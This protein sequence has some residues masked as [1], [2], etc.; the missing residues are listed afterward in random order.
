MS[1]VC[2]R[3][4]W[5]Q[6]SWQISST[7]RAP[8][9][10]GNG[11]RSKPARVWPQRAQV[12]V[13]GIGL[14]LADEFSSGNL[15]SWRSGVGV[16]YDR[17]AKR[18]PKRANGSDEHGGA[19]WR[20]RAGQTSEAPTAP[21]GSDRGQ[22]LHRQLVLP[23]GRR[24][25][26]PRVLDLRQAEELE[27]PDVD[28]PDVEL[29][30]ARLELGALR[31]GVMVV[32][33]LLAA[34]PDGDGGDVPAL[35]LHVEVAI[36]ERV[37]DAIDDA[38]RPERDPDHLHA[39]HERS[40]EEAEQPDVDAEHQQDAD[41]VER[42]EQMPL[43]PVGGRALAVF[44]EHARLAH[45]LAVVERALEQDLAQSLDH[46]A[47]R[48]ALAIGERVVLAMAGDPFLGD[49]GRGE[50]EPEAHRRRR[51]SVESDAAMGLRPMKKERDADVRDV[52][53]DDD[54][55]HG[56]PP[57]ACPG[58]EMEHCEPSLACDVQRSGRSERPPR[59]TPNLTDGR[60]SD[61]ADISRQDAF[62]A[63]GIAWPPMSPLRP[64]VVADA[65]GSAAGGVP[66]ASFDAS[67]SGTTSPG[68]SRAPMTGA[69]TAM[70]AWYWRPC[71]QISTG[72]FTSSVL[73]SLKRRRMC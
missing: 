59:R 16:P 12:T 46:R 44:L 25:V 55:E 43:E 31:I 18:G 69:F 68:Q 64:P 1:M 20:P 62:R 17:Q 2:W 3:S 21:N 11:G 53:C 49:D 7:T 65:R 22:P 30:P 37:A 73:L 40:D 70:T 57:L 56:H 38:G 35:V 60:T 27:G 47:V 13:A 67:Q 34:E 61:H 41:P 28:P 5:A 42:R 50:P 14:L 23:L 39:P 52:P 10:P 26:V 45:G 8:M 51:N 58:T 63:H 6:Q 4:H 66:Q 33:E 36:A 15:H 48:V 71:D 54:E 24:A 19:S 9:A 32:V 29:E 72:R